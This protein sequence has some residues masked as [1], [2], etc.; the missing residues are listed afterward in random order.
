MLEILYVS[1]FKFAKTRSVVS[2]KILKDERE[3]I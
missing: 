3:E 1:D 2:V